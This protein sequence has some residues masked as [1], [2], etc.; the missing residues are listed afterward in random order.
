M[1]RVSERRRGAELRRHIPFAAKDVL[2]DAEWTARQLERV[3]DA[4]FADACERPIAYLA[5]RYEISRAVGDEPSGT[6]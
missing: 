5:E 1:S 2:V 6:K 4:I 3:F